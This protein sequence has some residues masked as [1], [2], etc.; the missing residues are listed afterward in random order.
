MKSVH[1]F[2]LKDIDGTARSLSEY[3]GRVLLLVNV[4]SKC[5]LTPQYSALEQLHRK[6]RDQGFSVL[7]LPCNDFAGQ[8]PAAESEIKTFCSTQYDVTFPLFSK[9]KVLGADKAPLYVFL[10][11]QSTQPEGPG[12][13]SWNF[14][15]FLI[16]KDGQVIARFSPKTAPNAP[17]LVNA[18]EAALAR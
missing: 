6:Y 2:T 15:K 4:A 16:G 17:E 14:G 13:V 5:G 9:L 8:E 11:A 10:T 18:V 1:D 12:E 7:G 3:R